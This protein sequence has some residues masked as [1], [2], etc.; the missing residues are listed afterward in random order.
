MFARIPAPFIDL[1]S[2]QQNTG[3]GFQK[4]DPNGIL[5][6]QS[7]SGEERSKMGKPTVVM[8]N[9]DKYRAVVLKVVERVNGQPRKLEILLDDEKTRVDGGEEFIIGYFPD[10]VLRK[11]N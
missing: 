3:N 8:I 2:L 5:K 9:R 10:R 7:D 11:S 4:I 1:E 6:T